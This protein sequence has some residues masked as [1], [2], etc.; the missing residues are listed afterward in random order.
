MSSHL[1]GQEG[2]HGEGYYFERDASM[3]ADYAEMDKSTGKRY[4]FYARAVV[5]RYAVSNDANDKR[6][7][8]NGEDSCTSVVDDVRNPTIFVLSHDDQYY[9]EYLITF[10]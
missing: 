9:P 1:L 10:N 5:G 7:E 4:M 8:D 3:S 2:T 6:L